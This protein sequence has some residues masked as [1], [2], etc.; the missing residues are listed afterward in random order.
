MEGLARQIRQQF[1]AIAD[2]EFLVPTS[3]L[4]RKAV[5]SVRKGKFMFSTEQL[6]RVVQMVMETK[7]YLLF[8]PKSDTKDYVILVFGQQT[9]T[10]LVVMFRKTQKR[11]K[12]KFSLM[13]FNYDLKWK[14]S[15]HQNDSFSTCWTTTL[16][17]RFKTTTTVTSRQ[18]TISSWSLF[19]IFWRSTT[20]LHR[21]EDWPKLVL[22]RTLNLH[23]QQLKI[24]RT[25]GNE[26][27]LLFWVCNR[28]RTVWICC[29][30]WSSMERL[31]P[32]IANVFADESIYVL[33]WLSTVLILYIE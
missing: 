3:T 29:L 5:V 2:S 18:S 6:S 14:T 4:L 8:R 22:L 10:I 11:L 19:W 16:P 28:L 33:N 32:E 9:T 20:S 7:P 1:Q 15:H 27:C 25:I 17:W 23:K 12:K 26:T 21:S 30:S 24:W 13:G 31:L